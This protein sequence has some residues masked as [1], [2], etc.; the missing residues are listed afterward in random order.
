V[1]RK[2]SGQTSLFDIVNL[3]PKILPLDDWSYIFNKQ[4]FPLIDEEKF[5]GFYETD[6][7]KGGRP[8]KPVNTMLS[9][10]IFMAMEKLTWREAEFQFSRRLD[11]LLATNT[12][13]NE[14]W[15][16][17]TTLYYFYSKLEEDEK[18]RDLFR[19]LTT[20][21]AEACGTSLDKQRTDSFLIHGW[22]QIL[23]RYGLFKETIRTFLQNLRK[24]KPGLYEDINKELSREYLGKEFDL[25]EKDHEKA[26]RQIKVMSNDM[27]ILYKAFE[28]HNQVKHYQS[29]KT[30]LTVFDQQC[31]VKETNETEETEEANEVK[32]TNDKKLE[33]EILDK[34]KGKEIISSP[35]N[36]DARYIKK[37]KQKVC[38]HKGFLTESCEETN[39]VQFITDV[40]LTPATKADSTELPLIHARL[41][42]SEMKPEK[43]YAD[44]GFVNGETIIASQG[45]GIILEGPSSG[46]SQSFEAYESTDRPLDVADFSTKLEN[47]EIEVISC[48]S[49]QKPIDQARSDKTDK[50]NVHFDAEVCSGCNKK[51]RCPVKIGKSTATLN[52][53]EKAHAG[54]E[55]HHKYMEDSDYRKE[56]AIRAGAESM[57]SE[58]VRAHGIRKS[59]HRSEFR[60]RLQLIFAAIACNTKRFIRYQ[61]QYVQFSVIKA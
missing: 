31:E 14:A 19:K 1:F 11:W 41:E 12:P 15:I 43:Q 8:H 18:A 60:T 26:Q 35:H 16:D 34:P 22:L 20:K 24:Q 40:E 42:E 27:Y 2:S 3:F 32:E 21:F 59:R 7:S 44:A 52:I 4:I 5:R 38:G 53:D 61:G 9:L 47:D 48:P 55:R 13:L 46:R 54:A 58:I 39:E 29:F 57:V 23:S 25:T 10:L 50:I 51:D 37:G 28:N 6:N 56:C 30:L 17:H 49:G 45:N 36:T 33:I